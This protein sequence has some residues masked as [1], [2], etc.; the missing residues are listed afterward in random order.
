MAR[1]LLYVGAWGRG[2]GGRSIP[3]AQH[4]SEDLRPT[5][6]PEERRR[7]PEGSR[8]RTSGANG[9]GPGGLVLT[10]TR[11]SRQWRFPS[12]RILGAATCS[13]FASGKNR[14]A[15]SGELHTSFS[16]AQDG[17]YLGL[18]NPAG[19]L[20]D[21]YPPPFPPHFDDVSYGVS[22]TATD[23]VLL[24]ENAVAAM[25]VPVD[26]A[27]GLDWTL[28]ALRDA[29]WLEKRAHRFDRDGARHPP[30]RRANL[31][32]R[33]RRG[34]RAPA[35]A[36]PREPSTATRI[37]PT[38][39]IDNPHETAGRG[40]GGVDLGGTRSYLTASSCGTASLLLASVTTSG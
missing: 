31:A 38:G 29:S 34:S 24:P 22:Q 13:C 36:R 12:P 1:L 23:S 27:A 6:R 25:R 19:A 17:E 28:P 18:V 16:L 20:V 3:G 37:R 39:R 11:Y 26:G 8:S 32:R 10:D 15:A 9:L 7:P 35:A 40:G 14:A 30:G 21:D 5:E 2:R 4:L 33:G